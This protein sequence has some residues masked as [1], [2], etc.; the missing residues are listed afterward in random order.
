MALSWFRSLLHRQSQSAPRRRRGAARPAFRPRLEALETRLAPATWTGAGQ[1]NNW[2]DRF[3]WSG[4]VAPVT[5]NALVFPATGVDPNSKN[6]VNDFTDNRAFSSIT[7]NGSGYNITGQSIQILGGTITA[8]TG[9]NSL[10]LDINYST[11]TLTGGGTLTLG[12]ALA[13]GNITKTGFSRFIL[14]HDNPNFT[15]QMLIN[16]GA[17]VV[18]N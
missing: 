9:P 13:G 16:G 11:L 4:N 5:G 17:I 3:N 14:S 10:N 1:T 8:G 2:S 7:I 18:A 6:N 15:G 12:G